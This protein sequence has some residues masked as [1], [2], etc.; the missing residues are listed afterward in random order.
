MSQ[1]AKLQKQVPDLRERIWEF[2]KSGL[3]VIQIARTLQVTESSLRSFIKT[4]ASLS[5]L[6]AM[7]GRAKQRAASRKPSS[8]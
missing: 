2:A 8:A 4:D 7:N 1:L 3:T 5:V 6:L